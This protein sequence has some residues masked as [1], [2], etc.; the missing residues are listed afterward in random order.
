[1]QFI[2]IIVEM[3]TTEPF[4]LSVETSQGHHVPNQEKCVRYV[5]RQLSTDNTTSRHLEGIREVT[6]RKNYTA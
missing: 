4:P 1:M 2:I 6:A 3:S 5:P